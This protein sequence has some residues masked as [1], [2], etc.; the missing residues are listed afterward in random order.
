MNNSSAVAT[1]DNPQL[2]KPMIYKNRARSIV[3]RSV[4]NGSEN[5][6]TEQ[7][8][9]TSIRDKIRRLFSSK[10]D[11][12]IRDMQKTKLTKNK[13]IQEQE[14]SERNVDGF[15][16]TD[17]QSVEWQPV[18]RETCKIKLPVEE[19]AT[20]IAMP[21]EVLDDWVH[22]Q[23][24]ISQQ[25]GRRK[26]GEFVQDNQSLGD[27]DQGDDLLE[28]GGDCL[29]GKNASRKSC[30]LKSTEDQYS[31][32]KYY[33]N[34]YL[35]DEYLESLAASPN[36]ELDATGLDEHGQL[37]DNVSL[38]ARPIIVSKQRLESGV[39]YDPSKLLQ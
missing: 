9:G 8:N 25:L 37:Y 5:Q 7:A 36:K 39:P 26:G 15:L 17:H 31:K 2:Q 32:F 19:G 24:K 18:Y 30:N 11:Q 34:Y 1:G 14:P 13:S 27:H 28:L 33:Y 16:S 10:H 3:H 22:S 38:N 12:T 23:H 6:L 4:R 29:L 21:E 35:V 20:K